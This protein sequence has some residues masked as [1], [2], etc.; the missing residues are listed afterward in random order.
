MLRWI[1]EVFIQWGGKK[2]LG[3][4]ISFYPGGS[5]LKKIR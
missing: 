4:E 5:K 1:Q 3:Y 2:P